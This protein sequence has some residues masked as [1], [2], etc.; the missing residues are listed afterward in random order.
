[1]ANPCEL[2]TDAGS[3][4]SARRLLELVST[5]AWRVEDKFSRYLEDNIVHRINGSH[6]EP[7]RV[8]AET[9][10]L[11]D[12]CDSLYRLSGGLFDITS[13]VLREAWQFDGGDNV[14]GQHRIDAILPRIGWDRVRWADRTLVLQPGMQ[15]DLG[16]VGKEYAV[17]RCAGLCRD[18]AQASCLINLGGDIAVSRPR[19]SQPW[20]VGIEAVSRDQAHQ[21]TI[22]L[23][24]G[25]VATS[26]DSR[27]FLVKDGVRYSHIL[28]PRTGWPVADA[29][30]AVT[31]LAQSCTQAGMMATLASL[32]GVDAEA[33]LNAQGVRY[34]IQR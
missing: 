9:A 21:P 6:G 2:L 18:Q 34:W 27:Q 13:G 31:V 32:Q 26:G 10:R 25:G 1:M 14:P 28:D 15:I 20:R 5:E 12:F 29:P 19:E 23:N 33:F 17:D 24:G 30:R 7:V 16:G 11:L 4:A 8:D 3:A 22:A